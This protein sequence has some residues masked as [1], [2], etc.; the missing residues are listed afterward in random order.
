MYTPQG[1]WLTIQ[2]VYFYLFFLARQADWLFLDSVDQPLLANAITNGALA[3]RRRSKEEDM[4]YFHCCRSF[5]KA[6]NRR[7]CRSMKHVPP[8]VSE[9]ILCH[10]KSYLY[11]QAADRTSLTCLVLNSNLVLSRTSRTLSYS[12]DFLRTSD[13]CI[14]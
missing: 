2:E 6:T 1:N 7:S 9:I 5:G 12:T 13:F 3:V 11:W 10:T 8:K 14:V 4:K